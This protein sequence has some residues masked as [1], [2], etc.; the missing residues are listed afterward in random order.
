MEQGYPQL[1]GVTAQ[2]VIEK[3][4]QTCPAP[5][6]AAAATNSLTLNTVENAEYSVDGKMWQDSPVFKNLDAGT[7]YTLYQRLKATED[8]NYEV[9]PAASAQFSTEYTTVDPGDLS[10]V[11]QPQ[12]RPYTGSPVAYQVPSISHVTKSTVTYTVDGQTTTAAP[13]NAEI[14][15]AH[16]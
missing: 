15:R 9:S 4:E 7:I 10:D 8:G 13:T 3:A 12:T 6:L 11:L 16:V 2:Y 14:G 1:S 5:T